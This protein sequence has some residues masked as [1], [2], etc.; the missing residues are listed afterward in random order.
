MGVDVQY[1]SP[2]AYLAEDG[3]DDGGAGG[4]GGGHVQ[5]IELLPEHSIGSGVTTTEADNV[6]AE[7][8]WLPQHHRRPYKWYQKKLFNEN[9][10][11]LV[12]LLSTYFGLFSPKILLNQP[13]LDQQNRCIPT[14][15]L[16][17]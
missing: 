17:C 11:Y 9:F 15:Q 16:N 2:L 10:L 4:V 8:Q 13:K 6:V 3:L 7:V 1:S 12:C 5:G 14:Q